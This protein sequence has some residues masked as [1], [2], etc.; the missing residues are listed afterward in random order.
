MLTNFKPRQRET[1][2]TYTLG[3]WDKK[4]PGCGIGF[5]CDANGAILNPLGLADAAI[6]NLCAML[7]SPD[8]YTPAIESRQHSY[9]VSGSGRCSCGRTVDIDDAMTN[10]CSCGRLY[11]GS[12]QELAHPSQWGEETDERYD[13]YG[14]EVR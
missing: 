9:M 13:D 14:R 2:T 11:N 1:A 4:R 8:R 12:G 3:A 5:D 7:F 10:S 6:W